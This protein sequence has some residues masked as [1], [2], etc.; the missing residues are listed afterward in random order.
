LPT[1]A[2]TDGVLD[3]TLSAIDALAM[4]ALVAAKS[5]IN[6]VLHIE[7]EDFTLGPAFSELFVAT[8]RS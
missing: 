8:F 6:V 4:V 7:E 3:L 2:A 5:A 1:T